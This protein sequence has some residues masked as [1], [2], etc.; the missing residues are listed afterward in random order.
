MLASLRRDVGFASPP[1]VFR[2]YRPGQGVEDL[3]TGVL[4]LTLRGGT[5][6]ALADGKL[7]H[8]AGYE[9]DLA[10]K[11][12]ES[13]GRHH[14]LRVSWE[15]GPDSIVHRVYL[16]ARLLHQGAARVWDVRASGGLIAYSLGR[17]GHPTALYVLRA[18]WPKPIKIGEANGLRL[19]GWVGPEGR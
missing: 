17:S 16:G 3:F 15:R 8:S 11:T 12:A 10:A 9:V 14:P 2:A 7:R 19:E 1:H 13:V 6:E 4:G 18:E 5:L